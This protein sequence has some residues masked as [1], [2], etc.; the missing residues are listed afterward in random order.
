MHSGICEIALQRMSRG[1]HR[2][3]CCPGTDSSKWVVVTWRSGTRR[4][5]PWEHPK[6]LQCQTT[7]SGL[8]L[9][10]GIMLVVPVM[11]TRVTCPMQE[12]QLSGLLRQWVPS[13]DGV[14]TYKCFLPGSRTPCE[15]IRLSWIPIQR[16]RSQW[17]GALVFPLVLVSC[18]T[19]ILVAGD[20][21]AMTVMR[22]MWRHCFGVKPQDK[23]RLLL[24]FHYPFTVRVL[25]RFD[26]ITLKHISYM[27]C[28]MEL[29]STYV[30]PF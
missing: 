1:S 22:V 27:G 9:R 25:V 19:N 26:F 5:N 3:R 6:E 23:K 8:T 10:Y 24:H 29:S 30:L 17:C 15:R 11:A 14:M 2:W 4:W 28:V 7:C 18:W 12:W 21:D 13:Y 16:A 20:W